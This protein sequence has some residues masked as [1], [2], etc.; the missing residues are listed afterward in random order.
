[1]RAEG[2][3]FG[4]YTLTRNE[5][6]LVSR[7][8]AYVDGPVRV[9]LKTDYALRAIWGLRTPMI[10]RETPFYA[11]E[12]HF[13]NRMKVPFR[14]G[15]IFT[16]A[17]LRSGFDFR[18]EMGKAKLYSNRFAGPVVIDGRMDEIERGLAKY[19]P[20][21]FVITGEFGCMMFYLVVNRDLAKTG[22]T[23]TLD[24]TDDVNVSRPP[25][26]VPGSY[27]QT[28]YRMEHVLDIPR[29]DHRFDVVFY[30][31]PACEGRAQD[32]ALVEWE[33]PLT[34]TVR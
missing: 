26:N 27:G 13:P 24:Y 12:A 1:M 23:A 21:W 7:L 33:N 14:L 17:T 28:L 8:L 32:A 6:D 30:F 25:E 9:V 11:Y 29:G 3:L 16:E 22:V 4:V 10:E 20:T 2:N 34:V 31:P 19:R 18:P 15:R 5:E